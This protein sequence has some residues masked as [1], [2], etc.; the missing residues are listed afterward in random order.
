MC[1]L[2]QEPPFCWVLSVLL[3]HYTNPQTVQE[4]NVQRVAQ[5]FAAVFSTVSETEDW[6]LLEVVFARLLFARIQKA[7]ERTPQFIHF[8]T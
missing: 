5:L 8:G 1:S 6:F 3:W 2:I 7:K 4:V